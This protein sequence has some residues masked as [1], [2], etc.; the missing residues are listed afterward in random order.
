MIGSTPLLNHST[1]SLR[2]FETLVRKPHRTAIMPRTIAILFLLFSTWASA[3]NKPARFKLTGVVTGSDEFTV[4]HTA[5][6]WDGTGHETLSQGPVTV[7]FAYK[8]TAAPDCSF[9]SY[10]VTAH[11]QGQEQTVSAMRDGD[12]IKMHATARGES[13]D[14]SVPF[15][16]S[17]ILLDNSIVGDF[18][19]VA[20]CVEKLKGEDLTFLVPQRLAAIPGKITRAGE[21]SG[22]QDGKPVHLR[23]YSVT[24]GTARVDLWFDASTHE[25]MRVAN[26]GQNFFGTRQ[27]FVLPEK[28]TAPTGPVGW[29]ER[30]VKFPSAEF[31]FPATLCL[32]KDLKGK[33]PLVVLVHGSGPHDRDETIGPNKPFAEIAHGLADSDIAS[34]RYDKRTYAFAMQLNVKTL[35]LDQEVTDDAVAALNFAATQPEIDATKI[36]V[37][38]HSLGGTMAPYIAQKYPKLRGM[39]L[40]AGAARPIDQVS[41]DQVRFELKREG[42]SDAEVQEIMKKQQERYDE[43]RKAP[44]EQMFNGIS[45]GYMR[46]WLARDPAKLLRESSIPALVL[47]GGRDLQVSVADYDMLKAAIAGK[48]NN[49]SHLFPNL[50]HLFSVAPPNQTFEDIRKPAHVDPQVTATIAEWIKK[51]K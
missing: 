8:F 27:G 15:S 24:L 2:L 1:R 16:P 45:A 29:V 43:M 38:G 44:A 17:L 18:Q 46:D 25:L 10:E 20:D 39:I 5:S 41:S 42:K 4:T 31:Q 26:E 22:T 19:A 47:Q 12:K 40:M 14:K 36:F 21:E 51:L 34:L 33:V 35:T 32:P 13:H 3:Q 7:D 49:E 28:P 50:T 11:V 9:Q 30:E 23:K 48:P 37:L 6:G